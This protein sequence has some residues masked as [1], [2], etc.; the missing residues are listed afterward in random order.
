[1][2]WLQIKPF[3]IITKGLCQIDY[4]TFYLQGDAVLGSSNLKN[5][6][7]PVGHPSGAS[8]LHPNFFSGFL[9]FESST[10]ALI[11]MLLSDWS[12]QCC[13][14]MPHQSSGRHQ[15]PAVCHSGPKESTSMAGPTPVGWVCRRPP[16]RGQGVYLSCWCWRA[17][18]RP[19][20]SIFIRTAHCSGHHVCKWQKVDTGRHLRIYYQKL[21][22]LSH[23]WQRLAGKFLLFGFFKSF[24]EVL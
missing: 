4:C 22:I 14:L 6:P 9:K 13:Q 15:V 10:H 12:P 8:P 11:I 3:W 7:A 23:S 2:P 1:M 5:L 17:K 24:K 20:T 16:T 18:G 19:Q 21:P